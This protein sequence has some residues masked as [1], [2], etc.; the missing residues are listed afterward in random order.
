MDRSRLNIS[1]KV[2]KKLSKKKKKVGK[3]S[4]T[5][6]GRGRGGRGRIFVVPRPGATL[7]HRVKT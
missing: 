7:S 3:N 5:V 4:E 6:R 1:S 2:V